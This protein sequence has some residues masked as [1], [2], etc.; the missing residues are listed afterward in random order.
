MSLLWFRDDVSNKSWEKK[1]PQEVFFS[2]C[3]SLF[4]SWLSVFVLFF[5]LRWKDQCLAF[6]PFQSDLPLS[7]WKPHTADTK[8]TQRPPQE[9]NHTLGGEWLICKCIKDLTG[10]KLELWCTVIYPVALNCSQTQSGC[11]CCKWCIGA[12]FFFFSAVC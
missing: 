7:S 3:S 2:F 10:R 6:N 11:I 5:K 4:S 9:E 12:N 8:H 1:T